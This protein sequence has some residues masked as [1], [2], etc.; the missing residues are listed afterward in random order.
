MSENHYKIRIQ[1]L[2]EI[3]AENERKN[4]KKEIEEV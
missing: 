4:R 3:K 1:K 2:K